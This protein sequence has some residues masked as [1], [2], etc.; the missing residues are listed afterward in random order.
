[1]KAVF[2]MS[3]TSNLRFILHVSDFHL[4]DSSQEGKNNIAEVHDLLTALTQKLQEEKIK[5]DYLVHTGDVIDSEDLYDLVATEME[6][7]SSFWKY[8]YDKASGTAGKKFLYEE[9]K[10]AAKANEGLRNPGVEI[11]RP[12]MKDLIEFDSKVADHVEGRFQR[13]AGIMRSFVTDLNVAFGNVVICSGN[14]DVLRPLSMDEDAVTCQEGTSDRWEYSYPES[15]SKI[16]RHFNDFLDELGTANCIKRCRAR[17]AYQKEKGKDCLQC[18]ETTFCALDNMNVLILNTNWPN[19]KKQRPGYYCVHCGQVLDTIQQ[20][21]GKTKEPNKLNVIIA[22]KPVYEIC[23][24]A[25]LSFKRYTKTTFFSMLQRFLGD[26]GIYLCGD[27]HTRSIVSSLFH[28]IPHY[29]GG[30]PIRVEAGHISEVEYNLLAISNGH[31]DMKRKLHLSY[32]DGE[33]KCEIRPQDGTV[34]RLY[35]FC[36]KYI[37]RECFQTLGDT[38]SFSTWEGLCQVIHNWTEKERDTWYTNIDHLYT[39]ICRYRI[40]GKPDCPRYPPKDKLFEFVQQRIVKQMQHSSA[41]NVLNIRGEH[42]AG[43]SMFLGQFYIHL[44]TEYSKGSIDFIPAYFNM[45]N[46]EIY[47]QIASGGTYYE[48]VKEAFRAF[49]K[50]VQKLAEEEHQ[51]VCYLVDG[52]DELDCW[53]H[54]TEDSVG[55]EL[56]NTLAEYNNAWYVMAFSQH[57]LPCFKNTM[58]LRKY[59]DVSDIMYFNPV[60]VNEENEEHQLTNFVTAYLKCKQFPSDEVVRLLGNGNTEEPGSP[61]LEEALHTRREALL[62]D[63]C[64]IVK[65]FRRL[66]INPGFLS[67]N[68]KYLTEIDWETKRLRHKNEDI[69]KVYNYYIDR[70]YERCLEQLSYGFIEYAP[71]MA[72]LFAYKGYTYERFKRLHLDSLQ[73]NQ[74]ILG[75]ICNNSQRVYHTFL[76]IMKN[77]DTREYL[78]ALHYN[79]ELRYYAEHPMESIDAD[80]ILNEFITRNIAIL[81]RKLWTDTNKFVIACEHLLR[82]KDLGNCA[83][84]ML[85]YCLAHLQMYEPIRNRLQ[86]KMFQKSKE[87]LQLQGLW[88]D[89]TEQEFGKPSDNKFS[90]QGHWEITGVNDEEKL[91]RFQQLSLK[92]SMIVSGLISQRD[93]GNWMEYYENNPVFWAYNRQHQMLYYGDLSI[94]GDANIHELMPGR[95]LVYVGFDFHDC[96][97]YLYVKLMGN[98]TYPLCTYD[99]FTMLDLLISRLK[100]EHLARNANKEKTFF[101]RDKDKDRVKAVL[102]QVKKILNVFSDINENG[103][104]T[105]YKEACQYFKK[106][107]VNIYNPDHLW[108]TPEAE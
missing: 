24:K 78:I 108:S 102:S 58:P 11:P 42:S 81:I 70:Q 13:A 61:A 50:D 3:D 80:S 37:S 22:H 75:P 52:L 56:L 16:S 67:Q 27:K 94:K 26:G 40:N 31:V 74:H 66:T 12:N 72:Y 14:H 47:Q 15:V 69:F 83:Q 21:S 6:I 41:P 57:N 34:K 49:V 97:N 45:E 30:E 84:S 44:M 99:L 91:I 53:S 73:E 35:K 51:P 32:V 55:R 64:Q 23:E 68:E 107:I 1:M 88:D 96:F 86:N 89:S 92:H 82:R 28:D 7:G 43:K 33:W 19:P 85:I 71:A 46:E 18:G 17:S 2:K 106:A 9:Y 5:V 38:S 103:Q 4:N 39:P 76:F 95:D 87:T 25:R 90:G 100:C 101:Y 63:V 65:S 36:Q 54:S 59:N 62:Q 8:E 77:K 29:I 60:D 93:L 105:A 104:P 98:R 20:H 48:A 79:R 10:K